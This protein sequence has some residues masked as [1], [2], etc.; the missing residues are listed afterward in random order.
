MQ[1]KYN[2][3]S[4]GHKVLYFRAQLFFQLFHKICLNWPEVIKYKKF[5]ML[6]SAEHKIYP[7]HKC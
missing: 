5:T 2:I 3:T 6:N 1:G 7:A 4:I